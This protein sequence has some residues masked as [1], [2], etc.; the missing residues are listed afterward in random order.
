MLFPDRQRE[1]DRRAQQDRKDLEA[2]LAFHKS[3]QQDRAEALYR[4]VLRRAPGNVDALHLLGIIAHARGRNDHAVQL[5]TRA[6]ALSP[7]FADAHQNLGNA[8]QELGRLDE[9]VTSYRSAISLRPDLAHAHANL[10]AAYNRQGLHEAALASATR[11]VELSPDFAEAHFNLG[12]ALVSLRRFAEAEAA[13]RK[14]LEFQ[15]DKPE[16][17]SDLGQVLLEMKRPE[18]AL[19]CQQRAVELQPANA[20]FRYRL[21]AVQFY[22]G[23]PHASEASCRSAVTLDPKNA[24][25]WSSLGQIL[26][27]LGRFDEARSCLRRALELDPELPDAY[28]GLAIL[29]QKGGGEQQL[30]RLHTLMTR[31]SYPTGVR[32][33]AGFALGMLLDNADRYDEAFPCF[34]QA[35]SLYREMLVASGEGHDRAATRRRIDGLIASCSGEFF[36]MVADEGIR[37][38]VPVFIVGMPR[39]G[40]SLVEQIAA[41]HSRVAG[42]GELPDLGLI[43]DTLSAHRGD[44]QVAEPNPGLARQLADHYVARLDA[45]GNGAPRVIDKMPDN[46]LHMGLAAVLFPHARVIFCRRDPRDT[47][48]S[49]YFR[50]FDQPIPWAYDLVDCGARALEIERLAVHWRDVLPLRTLTIDYE[51]LVADLEAESRR[52]ISFLGLDWEQACL[53][54]DKTERPVLTASGWQVRQPL[55]SRSVGRWRHYH[56]YLSPLLDILTGNL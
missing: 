27:S 15:P 55:Y 38:E 3:G 53:D 47:C 1:A 28:A 26:R 51:A 49:C 21:G 46:I 43:V 7:G 40:T 5:L 9:A 30:S 16:A 6:V 41:T 44:G 33:D 37:S 11:A 54:F 24:A 14:A 31:A 17:L 29:G 10:A 4:K 35:N 18:E 19:A 22:R 32:V 36:S 34:D 8:L 13:Y 25:A 48:L 42:A 50:R 56:R 23:D 52:L 20:I 12:A 39:S 2:G 45:L